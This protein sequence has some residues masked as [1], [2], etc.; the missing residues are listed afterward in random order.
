MTVGSGDPHLDV[1]AYTLHALPPDEEAAF[2]HHLASCAACREEADAL[3][4]TAALLAAGQLRAPS[5]EVR[6][7]VLA[8]IGTVPQERDVAPDRDL[9]QAA[10]LAARRRRRGQRALAFALAASVA[11]AAALGG[12]AWWQHS[13]ADTA[14]EQIREAEAGAEALA[15]VL[16]ASDATISTTTLSDGATASVVTSRSEGEAAFIAAG[17]PPLSGDQVYELWYGRGDE[18]WP[19]GLLPGTGGDVA[20]VMEGPL[21]KATAVGITV[22]PAGG[23]PQPTTKPL[24]VIALPA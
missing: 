5:P 13:E 6:R 24:G 8:Q 7:R 11:A 17:L 10:A 20:H 14:R 22:E 15:G 23:S 19:A 21:S 9:E 1:G 16:A 2:E 3:A 12:I 18:H 4:A